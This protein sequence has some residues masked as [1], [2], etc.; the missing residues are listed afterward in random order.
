M[1]VPQG[2]GDGV[3]AAPR[4]AGRMLQRNQQP[5]LGDVLGWM[6]TNVAWW[7]WGGARLCASVLQDTCSTHL[8]AA[9]TPSVLTTFQPARLH[10]VETWPSQRWRE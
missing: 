10:G 5:P 4:V 1:G 6:T 3:E 2:D 7:G 9:P 8:Q